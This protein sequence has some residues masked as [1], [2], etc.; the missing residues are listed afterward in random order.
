MAALAYYSS[1]QGPLPVELQDAT[2]EQSSAKSDYFFLKTEARDNTSSRQQQT[3]LTNSLRKSIWKLALPCK[4]RHFLWK[5]CL[6]AIPTKLNLVGRCVIEDSTCSLCSHHH[7]DVLHALWSCPSL[8]QVWDDDPQW[9]FKNTIRF[10]HF[11]QLLHQVLESDCNVEFFAM[12]FSSSTSS[13]LIS[14]KIR[15][16]PTLNLPDFWK[17]QFTGILKSWEKLKSKAK[18]SLFVA[19]IGD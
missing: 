14:L 5:A 2:L 9:N 6:N 13:L 8:A 11:S 16:L 4:V 18:K 3:G 1:L 19:V 17:F 10:Q 7:E 12:L 15:P